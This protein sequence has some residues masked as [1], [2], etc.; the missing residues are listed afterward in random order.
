MVNPLECMKSIMD[1][2]LNNPCGQFYATRAY[3]CTR[4][5]GESINPVDI[6]H[7]KFAR[8][9]SGIIRLSMKHFVPINE[10]DTVE[11]KYGNTIHQIDMPFNRKTFWVLHGPTMYKEYEGNIQGP[12]WDAKQ[13]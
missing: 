12:M 13:L 8:V 3:L 11:V 10:I 2:C 5:R 6:L 4:R 7:N 9:Y 1:C